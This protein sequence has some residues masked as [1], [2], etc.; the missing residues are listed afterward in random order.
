MIC[1]NLW[2][3]PRE[4]FA[5][6]RQEFSDAVNSYDEYLAWLDGTETDYANRGH[7]VIRVAMTLAEM[8]RRLAAAHLENTTEN[9]AKIL[10]LFVS[11]GAKES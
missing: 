9:R 2:E 5:A 8:K 3:F 4:E 10:G 11:E 1:I 6:W 7:Q